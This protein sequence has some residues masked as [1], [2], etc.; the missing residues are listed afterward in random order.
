MSHSQHGDVARARPNQHHYSQILYNGQLFEVRPSDCKCPAPDIVPIEN[1]RNRDQ[2]LPAF[3]HGTMLQNVL[4]WGGVIVNPR[5]DNIEIK[6]KKLYMGKTANE[7]VA[8]QEQAENFRQY[9]MNIAQII[10]VTEYRTAEVQLQH[11][12]NLAQEMR[13]QL[14]NIQRL[15]TELRENYRKL[16][17]DRE[18]RVSFSTLSS[19]ETVALLMARCLRRTKS[20]SRCCK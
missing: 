11:F 4:N 2:A 8:L 9:R 20:W 10:A 18:I 15:E 12:E 16:A 14:E 13:Q 1:Q 3:P 19:K 5:I 6:D 17:V 7:A